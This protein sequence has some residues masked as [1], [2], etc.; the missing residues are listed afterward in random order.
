MV[1]EQEDVQEVAGWTDPYRP[2]TIDL[3][4][5]V[6]VV[7]PITAKESADFFLQSL[8]ICEDYFFYLA[9][10]LQLKCKAP[11][12]DPPRL[13][14]ALKTLFGEST[15][16]YDDYKCSF[17]YPFLLEIIRKDKK[18]AY[19]LNFMDIKGGISFKFRKILATPEEL[20]KYKYKDRHLLHEPFEDDFSQDEMAYF[21]TWFVFYLKGF[22]QS[23]EGHYQEEFARSLDYCLMI[24]GY[25][26]NRFFLDQYE[27]QDAFYAAARRIL[28]GGDI[29]FNRE[30]SNNFNREKER[31]LIL[32]SLAAKERRCWDG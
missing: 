26:D 8:P 2:I 11:D 19:A 23:F 12:F 29:P 25:R 6:C 30:K 27:D 9:L 15:T 21:M 1:S 22:M 24:Y 4:N 32:L 16:A 3:K 28:K 5:A 13:Y 7:T 20:E 14:A 17:G 31:H 10:D 18:S